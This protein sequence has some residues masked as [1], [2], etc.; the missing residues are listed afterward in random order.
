VVR[1][2]GGQQAGHTVMRDGKKH[3]CS[4]FGSGVLQ[5][6]P[7][8]LTEHC[9]FY[10]NT[11]AKERAIL[12][13]KGINPLLYI[14]PLAKLTTPYDVAH[15]RFREQKLGH[16][17]CGLGIG[18]TMAR[19]ITTGYKLHAIDLEFPIILAQK[20]KQISNYYASNL[21]L[22]EN[23][24]YLKFVEEETEKWNY[25]FRNMKGDQFLFVQDY[26]M[27]NNFDTVI[28]EGSQGIMLDMDHGIFPNVTFANTTSKNAI[29]VCKK[30][31]V[32]PEI[33]YIT[34]CYQTRHGAG[35]MSNEDS[36]PLINNEEEINVNNEW[37]KN[38]RTG[39]IDYDLLNY[40]LEVDR[41]YSSEYV[42][43]TNLVVT[44][45]DQRPDSV[46]F[47]AGRLFCKFNKIFTSHSPITN[48]KEA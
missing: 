38:F 15:N 40:S 26:E 19:N 9:T 34:R 29:E 42:K 47:D 16:G 10:P 18:S 1:F 4:N 35:W 23:E 6:V 24:T 37:Q 17:S 43:N 31:G 45:L 44:C 21:G 8:Y 5:D 30:L 22:G 13:D 12:Q 25:S 3:I 28:F 2:S 41:I 20:L 27:L 14:H 32:K 48:L 46:T 7:T 36:I 11:I 39:E 33:Y